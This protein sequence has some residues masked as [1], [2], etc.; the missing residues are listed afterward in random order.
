VFIQP[1]ASKPAPAAEP[2][3]VVE[4][5]K[6]AAKPKPAVVEEV[7]EPVVREASKP[8]PPNV[9]SILSDWADDADD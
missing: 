7:E 5:P 4:K 3:F 1:K 6:A 9:K 8:A 2:A